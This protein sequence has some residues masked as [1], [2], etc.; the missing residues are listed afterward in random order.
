MTELEFTLIDWAMILIYF[1]LL[2]YLTWQR[3]W[4]PD[5]EESYLLSGRKMSLPAFVATLVS[6]W[7]GG[8]L[9]VGEYSYQ[10]GISQWLLFGFPFYVF[11]ALFAWLLAG[12][13][14][15]NKALS[16][17]EAV[18]NFY[19]EK[20][21]RFS[22]L[23]IFILV[24][25]APY[26]LM[27][28][29]IFQYLTGGS[30]DFL[31]YASAV[32]LFSV[33]YVTFGG[34][35]AVVHTDML[36]I[37]LMFGGFISLLIF[38]GMDF[39]GMGQLWSQMPDNYRDITGGHDL[40][41]ILVWFFIALWTFVDPSFHQRAAA[42]KNPKTAK[43]GIFI[44]ILLWSVFDFL[45]MFSGIYGWAILG[46]DLAE[47]VMVYPYLAN[48]ILPIGFKGLFFVALLATIMSTL[49]SYLFLSGQ[50]LG[51]DFLVK[52]FPKVKNNTLTQ[53]S[54]IIA[55]I[56]GILLIIVYPSVIDL[57]YIIGSVMLPGLLIPV[58]GVYLR[59]FTLKKGWVLPTMVTSIGVSLL[60]LVIGTITAEG[61][62]EYKFLGMEPF[63]PGLGISILFWLVGRN[64]DGGLLEETEFTKEIT[65]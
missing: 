24:S 37:A 63:Y 54:I 58:L 13:I 35:S 62:Y 40:Q 26:I 28:G 30:G 18:G 27:L 29:L 41:Y 32:A 47:P 49:D 38:A 8:I 1:G 48:E 15:M 5:D 36:Q 33:A 22:A 34:F 51:R 10:F 59:F 65:E 42:A 44:S 31:W 64:P 9:G 45:T 3:D 52:F 19:G 6:T 12:K 14:R 43:K 57:W 55:A 50:T 25:P 20:A 4:D 2:V 11:S 60:W 53:I 23:P 56:L 7:Y 46:P 21:G 16:L 17:P 61:S 39:G